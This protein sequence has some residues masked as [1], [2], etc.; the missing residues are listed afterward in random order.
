MNTHLDMC[1]IITN[2]VVIIS[3]SLSNSGFYDSLIFIIAYYVNIQRRLKSICL[4]LAIRILTCYY[5]V[6]FLNIEQYILVVCHRGSIMHALKV[7]AC[8]WR[9][10]GTLNFL[11]TVLGTADGLRNRKYNLPKY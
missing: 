2:S 4:L 9:C 5:L 7:I 1:I 11:Q 10:G 3:V 6:L 8:M